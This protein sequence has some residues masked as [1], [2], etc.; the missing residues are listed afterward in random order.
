M[1]ETLKVGQNCPAAEFSTADRFL[2]FWS[3]LVNQ[4]LSCNRSLER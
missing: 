4:N 3:S 2:N 1:T